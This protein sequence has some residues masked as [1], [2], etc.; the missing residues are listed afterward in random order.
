M[1]ADLDRAKMGK[2]MSNGS[3]NDPFA[4]KVIGDLE[5]ETLAGKSS[6]N[7]NKRKNDKRKAKK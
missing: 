2:E 4:T 6:R 7:K 3:V 1:I 5:D